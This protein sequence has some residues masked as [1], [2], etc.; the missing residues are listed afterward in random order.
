MTNGI[1]S[2]VVPS[3]PLDLVDELETISNLGFTYC[4]QDEL[5]AFAATNARRRPSS[6]LDDSA[7][8][9]IRDQSH[10]SLQVEERSVGSTESSS[11][12][13]IAN[14]REGLMDLVRKEWEM[15]DPTKM[16]AVKRSQMDR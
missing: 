14:L 1:S 8:S 2:I 11:S 13:K 5:D 4:S 7:A 10:P 3:L 6:P 9:G 12:T 16:I 15:S